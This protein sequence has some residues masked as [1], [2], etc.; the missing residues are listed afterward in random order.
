[1]RF[2]RKKMVQL[3]KCV[4]FLRSL[5][6]KLRGFAKL[7]KMQKITPPTHWP[8]I[9]SGNTSLTSTEQSNHNHKQPLITYCILYSQNTYLLPQTIG[10]I[11]L[12][13]DNF[14]KKIPERDLS[15]PT[16]FKNYLVFWNSLDFAK[17][18]TSDVRRCWKYHGGILCLHL[19]NLTITVIKLLQEKSVTASKSECRYSSSYGLINDS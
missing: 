14:Q 3:I 7:T 4:L 11:G 5:H 12:F 19:N 9:Q 1:M 15:P 6:V 8:P 2:H 18:T 10:T 17:S 16:H 13:W